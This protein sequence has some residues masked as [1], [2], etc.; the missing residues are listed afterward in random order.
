M[1]VRVLHVDNFLFTLK[2]AIDLYSPALHF[3][4][5]FYFVLTVLTIT[6]AITLLLGEL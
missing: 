2:A 3:Y 6:L 4:Y 1:R 5:K